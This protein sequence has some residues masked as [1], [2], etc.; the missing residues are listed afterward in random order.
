MFQKNLKKFQMKFL[1]FTSLP[2]QKTD[3]SYMKVLSTNGN[4]REVIRNFIQ[5][6]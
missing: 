3:I 2:K 6:N 5:G 1:M 4:N